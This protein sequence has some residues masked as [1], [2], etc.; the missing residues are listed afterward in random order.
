MKK[1]TK[2][3]CVGDLAD[4]LVQTPAQDG[5]VRPTV[6]NQNGANVPHATPTGGQGHY[7]QLKQ[8]LL[9]VKFVLF[10]LEIFL[11]FFIADSLFEFLS[12]FLDSYIWYSL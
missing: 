5:T 8:N 2:R 7:S 1:K 11:Q 6:V 12:A 9:W 3:N 4:S 10:A